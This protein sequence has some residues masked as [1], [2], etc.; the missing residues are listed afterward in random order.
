V[1]LP[2]PLAALARGRAQVELEPGAAT[3]GGVL[4]ALKSELPAV[5]DRIVTEQGEIR[6]HIN[7]FVGTEDIRWSGGMATPVAAGAEVVVI[8]SV[9]GGSL[10]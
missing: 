7:V 6:P 4:S 8:P 2:A 1:V 10:R 5:Y 9:S 3:V